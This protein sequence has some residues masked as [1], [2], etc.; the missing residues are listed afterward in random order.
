MCTEDRHFVPGSPRL[1]II[2][3]LMLYLV[4]CLDARPSKKHVFGNIDRTLAAATYEATVEQT[5]K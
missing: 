4:P 1:G 5:D 3:M 2:T